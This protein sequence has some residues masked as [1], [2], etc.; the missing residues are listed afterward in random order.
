MASTVWKGQLTFGLVSFP[1]R[2]VRAAR[3]ER[4][5]LRYV[6]AAP[7]VEPEPE[8]S[9][10]D[11]PAD[12][13]PVAPVRQQ[14][15]ATGTAEPV[16]REALDRGYEVAPDEFVVV[17]QEEL[18]RLRVATS[19]EMQILRA[20]K[21]NEIDPVF[22]E[23]SYYVHPGANGEHAY[24]LFYKTLEEAG[25]AALAEVAMHGRSHVI[26][27]RA[28]ARGLIAHTMF[29]TNEVRAAEEY[30]PDAEVVN[31]RELA[32]ARQFVEAI[33]GPF[34]AAEFTDQY[35]AKLEELIA[36]KQSAPRAAPN[37]PAK[38]AG[39]VEDM[40]DALKRSLEAARRKPAV[41]EQA[42]ARRRKRAT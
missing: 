31:P 11:E 24:A 1:V 33:A 27:L 37:A 25:Y 21:M 36:S 17:K 39:R 8:A 30:K 18:R 7:S 14:Y 4:I 35:R 6:S 38:A 40:L 42:L 9:E 20:V 22:L 3:K 5:P 32:L 15:T 13:V 34:E 12:P 19:P 23:T 2:L 10:T 26:V 16:Q 41:A 29:Y 28:G